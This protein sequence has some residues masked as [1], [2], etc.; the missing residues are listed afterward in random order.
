[1]KEYVKKRVKM[2]MFLGTVGALSF[3][4]VAKPVLKTIKAYVNPGM[5]YTLNGEKVLN[6]VQTITYDNKT[7]VPIADVAKI[8]GIETK[9]EN[10]TLAL[11]TSRGTLATKSWAT[12]TDGA[13]KITPETTGTVSI[14]E[15]VIKDIKAENKLVTV[16]K[17]GA[18]DKTENYTI[19]NIT[20][21]TKIL[22]ENDTKTYTLSDLK[23]DMK[24]SVKHSSVTTSTLPIQ[25]VAF[26]IKILALASEEDKDDDKEDKDEVKTFFKDARIVEVNNKDKY[27]VIESGKKGNLKIAFSNKTK[28]KFENAKKQPNANALKEGQIA[29]IKVES[30]NEGGLQI[31]EITV[32]SSK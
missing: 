19:L 9:F 13:Y 20:D 1:M 24:V 2:I 21:V 4:L 25:T 7:Y 16:L 29:D 10:N 14:K 17:A 27:I 31:L 28:V 8:L 26:E 30:S 3:S 15:A 5:S 12:T 32:K 23:S 18:E 6:G 22:R 11:T